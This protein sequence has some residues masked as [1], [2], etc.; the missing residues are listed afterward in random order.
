MVSP[1][2]NA[3]QAQPVAPSTG[4]ATQKPTQS[5]PQSAAKTDSVQLSTAAQATLAAL[6]ENTETPAQTATEAGSGDPQAQRLLAKEAAS[7][8]VSK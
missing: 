1:I 7:K 8:S 6:H 2:T 3:T 5:K 4:T